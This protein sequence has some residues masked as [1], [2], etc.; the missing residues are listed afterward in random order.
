PREFLV[1]L[2]NAKASSL[3]TLTV[4]YFACSD[5]P[6]WCRAVE[7]E[8]TIH[9]ERDEFGGAVF[10]RTFIMGRSFKVGQSQKGTDRRRG[11]PSFNGVAGQRPQGGRPNFAGPPNAQVIFSRFDRNTDGK[12]TEG[13]VPAPL[14]K[15]LSNMDT[16]GDKLIT[17]EEFGKS[18]MKKD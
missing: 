11:R 17:L 9:I 6:A 12:L 1:D 18:R 5:D 3:L 7:Q 8:Y 4:R 16:D 13:E 10:G 14:W 15:R 2:K